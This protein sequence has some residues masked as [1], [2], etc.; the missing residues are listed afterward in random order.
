MWFKVPMYLTTIKQVT[1]YFGKDKLLSYT[2][3]KSGPIIKVPLYKR[4]QI[5]ILN[6]GFQV[7]KS[8]KILPE[9]SSQLFLCR[10]ISVD[11]AKP[12]NMIKVNKSLVNC[13]DSWQEHQVSCPFSQLLIIQYIYR[14]ITGKHLVVDSF[15]LVQF[16]G[17]L[18]YTLD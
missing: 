10:N 12:I 5:Y 2:C 3:P 4:L 6:L 11:R 15:E 14:T 13:P 7:I 18:E 9:E 8:Q 1:N 17:F 16:Q